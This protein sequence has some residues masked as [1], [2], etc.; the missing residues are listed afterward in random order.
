MI[1]IPCAAANWAQVKP[2]GFFSN[3]LRFAN[4]IR[5][6]SDAE[7]FTPPMADSY[8]LRAKCDLHPSFRSRT[9]QN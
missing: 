4:F 3:F 1:E 2:I 8:G 5:A 9:H 7:G 6:P